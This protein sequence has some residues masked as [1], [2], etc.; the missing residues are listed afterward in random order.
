M[1]TTH[2]LQNPQLRKPSAFL[3]SIKGL[4][5]TKNN[6]AKIKIVKQESEKPGFKE[7][8][9]EPIVNHKITILKD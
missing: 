8:E 5:K 6:G 1:L 2:H 9:S 3:N 7:D 4:S